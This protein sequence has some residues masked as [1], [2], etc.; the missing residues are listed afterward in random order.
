MKRNSH[1]PP[2]SLIEK[3]FQD[4][5]KEVERVTELRNLCE[6]FAAVAEK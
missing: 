6:E 5:D 3:T 4:T 2:Q 1:H